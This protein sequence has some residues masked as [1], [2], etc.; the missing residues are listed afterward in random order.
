MTATHGAANEPDNAERIAAAAL[1]LAGQSGWRNLA[2]GDIA[3]E[4]AVTLSE[5]ARHYGNRAEI[6]D[7]FERMIDRRMLAGAVAGDIGDKAR[8]RVFDI[9]M[10]R[11]DAL[12]PYRDGVRRVSRELAFD[13]PSSLALVCA[14]PRTV[15]WMCSRARRSQST[16]LS[17]RSKLAILG[18]VYVAA[19]PGLAQRRGPGFGQDHGGPGSVSST[20]P[21][22]C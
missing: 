7:G 19:L 14:L 21:S 12:L 2:L 1:H 22:A 5:L 10:E 18:A 6:L 15:T 20:A 11:F 16:A 8:D 9:I 13:A 17:C 4:A 3:A